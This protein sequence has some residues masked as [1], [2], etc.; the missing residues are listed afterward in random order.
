MK[1]AAY[2]SFNGNCR[3]A[4]LFYQ[5]CLGG[6]LVFQTI[7]DSPLSEKMPE[8]MKNCILHATLKKGQMEL[9]ATD[10][11]GV[12]ERSTGTALS[13]MLECKTKEEIV[14]TYNLLAH[15]GVRCH[16]LENTFF[17]AIIGD[18]KDQYG[19]QWILFLPQEK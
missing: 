2:L 15:G 3:E 11:M 17:G 8:K 9:M 7:G 5:Q 4:M 18:I 6:E 14:T 12:N 13:L 10:M 19:I 1:I 16:E